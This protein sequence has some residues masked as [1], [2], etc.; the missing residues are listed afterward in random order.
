MGKHD[1]KVTSLPV[2]ILSYIHKGYTR[3]KLNACGGTGALISKHYLIKQ[4]KL[5]FTLHF[6]N[7]GHIFAEVNIQKFQNNQT[8]WT[9]DQL[10]M[11]KSQ[12]VQCIYNLP[13]FALLGSLQDA[14]KHPGAG[15][16]FNNCFTNSRP[17]PLL[18]P[19]IK[20]DLGDILFSFK[21][22]K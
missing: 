15:F 7:L 3:S 18:A 21:I 6:D 1:V 17:I 10:R 4:C 14:N 11:T 8:K 19:D 20:I 16:L 9:I 12:S 22:Y 5:V 13:T 2:C